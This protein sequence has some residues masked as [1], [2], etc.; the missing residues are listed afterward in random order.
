MKKITLIL[1]VLLFSFLFFDYTYLVFHPLP[2]I[3]H[4]IFIDPGHGGRDPGAI[5]FNIKEKD[6]NLEISKILK[7]ELE[8]EGAIVYM[9]REEDIDYS[10]KYATRKKSLIFIIGHN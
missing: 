10:D 3:G 7:E 4:T 6:I 8:K 5:Y 9:T 1:I 2:L